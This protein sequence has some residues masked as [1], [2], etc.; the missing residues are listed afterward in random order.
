VTAVIIS[1]FQY[2]DDPRVRP[3]LH[4]RRVPIYC[5]VLWE[6]PRCTHWR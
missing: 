6:I 4:S 3:Y 2:L 1:T 5:S